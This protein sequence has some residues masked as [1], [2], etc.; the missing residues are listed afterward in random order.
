MDYNC[1]GGKYSEEEAKVVVVQIL[2]VIS[3]CHFQGV[4]HRDLKPEVFP[5]L[6]MDH[7]LVPWKFS[8]RNFISSMNVVFVFQ[9]FLFTSNDD[10]ALLKAIDFGLSDFVRPGTWKYQTKEKCLKILYHDCKKCLKSWMTDTLDFINRW[11][12]KWHRW[13]C[14]LCG[15]G[16]SS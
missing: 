9:N 8:K 7:S 6:C 2:S 16:G 14:I 13:K 11:K 12:T 5:I 3:F 15:T 1:R 10:N 4:V